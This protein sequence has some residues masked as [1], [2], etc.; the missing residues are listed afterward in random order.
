[1][2]WKST[3]NYVHFQVGKYRSLLH[4]KGEFANYLMEHIQNQDSDDYDSDKESDRQRRQ[5]ILTNVD[6]EAYYTLYGDQALQGYDAQSTENIYLKLE[7]KQFY[8]LFGD[9]TTGIVDTECF[10]YIGTL[11]QKR[12]TWAGSKTTH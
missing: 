2:F 4:S 7:T 6:P 8:A 9:F 1:M 10:V 5:S 12:I 11:A 3:L